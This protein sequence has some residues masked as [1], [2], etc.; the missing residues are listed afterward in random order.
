MIGGVIEGALEPGFGLLESL[1]YQFGCHQCGA[2]FDDEREFG[3]EQLCEGA[4]RRMRRDR[5]TSEPERAN[6]GRCSGVPVE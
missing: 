4:G 6:E 5:E 2:G 3:V 1:A